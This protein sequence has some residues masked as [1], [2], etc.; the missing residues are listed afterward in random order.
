M[1]RSSRPDPR[2]RSE[3]H[4]QGTIAIFPIAHRKSADHRFQNRERALNFEYDF[5][6]QLVTPVPKFVSVPALGE[7]DDPRIVQH[8]CCNTIPWRTVDKFNGVR[9]RFEQWRSKH[10]GQLKT[11]ADWRRWEEVQAGTIASQHGVRRSKDGVVRQALRIFRR[12][13]VQRYWGLPGGDYK[14]AAESLTAVGYPT[15]EQDFKNALRDKTP[16]PEHAIPADAP[17]IRELIV[18]L[19]TIWP[20]FDWRRLVRDPGPD[21]QRQTCPISSPSGFESSGNPQ[22][23]QTTA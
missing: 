19:L 22:E 18:T 5:K 2:A 10:A 14:R 11:E 4:E 23:F 21:Y 16:V 13:Y 15:K 3:V 9:D 20:E 6:R 7:D 8:I 17:G 12:A 1:V